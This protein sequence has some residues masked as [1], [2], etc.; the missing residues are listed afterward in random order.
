MSVE[1]HK[2]VLKKKVP[3]M[4][5][6]VKVISSKSGFIKGFLILFSAIVFFNFFVSKIS[7]SQKNWTGSV[8]NE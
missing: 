5:A 6:I 7:A 8:S 3:K 1:F 4:E 2:A